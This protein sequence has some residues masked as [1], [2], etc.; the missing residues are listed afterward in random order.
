MLLCT[1]L[2]DCE[3]V[4]TLHA[5][6]HFY[7]CQT[8]AAGVPVEKYV[9]KL[10]NEFSVHMTAKRERAQVP[11]SHQQSVSSSDIIKALEER[12]K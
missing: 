5:V 9:S 6:K 1:T 8:A 4:L 2:L 10:K 12:G 11:K 7:F 3:F